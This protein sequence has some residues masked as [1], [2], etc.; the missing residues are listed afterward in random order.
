MVHN[1]PDVTPGGSAVALA[2]SRTPCNWL[3]IIAPAGNAN[4]IRIGDSTTSATSGLAIVK[5]G[6]QAF[7]PISDDQYLDLAL[8]Y[9]Y[10]S[11]T[12]KISVVYGTH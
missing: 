1:I 10:G 3:Q 8:I 9:V 7:P 6:G 5:G 4:D 11:G 2:S 12:D